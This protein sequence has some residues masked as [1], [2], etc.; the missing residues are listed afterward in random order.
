MLFFT[1]LWLLLK[2]GKGFKRYM[3]FCAAAYTLSAAFFLLFRMVRICGL[4]ALRSK[5]FSQV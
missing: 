2:D 4:L 5:L 1:G 3:L